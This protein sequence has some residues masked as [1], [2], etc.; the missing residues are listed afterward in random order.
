MKIVYI[1]EVNPYENSGIVKKVNDQVAYWKS[2]GHNVEILM[3]WPRPIEKSTLFLRGK[4]ISSPII[5][6]L[7]DGF[8]K[9][10]L[11][12]IFCLSKLSKELIRIEPDIIYTR[13]NTWY[14]GIHS[15]YKKYMTVLELNTVDVLEV[16]YYP[17]LKRLV[18]LLGRKLILAN[19]NGLISVTPDILS[20]YSDF[21]KLKMGVVSNGINLNRI[22]KL[23]KP[24]QSSHVNFVFVGSSNMKWHG[25]QKVI[26]LAHIFPEYFFNIVGYKSD[27]FSNLPDNIKF[28]GWV[29]KQELEQIYSENHFGIGSFD[30]HLVGKPTDSTLKVREYL[31]YGLPVIIG[32]FDVDLKDADFVLKVTDDKG[33]FIDKE[34]IKEF[35]DSYKSISVDNTAL[36]IIDSA[37]KEEER[38]SFF[39]KLLN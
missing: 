1:F 23:K 38:L 34:N 24:G 33:D 9:N 15:I 32:H 36:E 39:R 13:Q 5:A 12:K 21:S 35:V 25:L 3:P 8:I 11:N 18:Y 10:Y 4:I 20:H 28:Y 29:E 6:R 19:V 2:K 26:D 37:T 16:K 30:N 7:K 17:K 22:N 31:A 14:P 27:G